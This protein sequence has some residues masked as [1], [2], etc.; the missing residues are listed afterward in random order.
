MATKRKRSTVSTLKDQIFAAIAEAKLLNTFTVMTLRHSLD[1]LTN[2]QK[3]EF[4]SS[5]TDDEVIEFSHDC[6]SVGFVYTGS[7]DTTAPEEIALGE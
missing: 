3:I 6:E 1:V 5:L 2:E 7:V 4:E